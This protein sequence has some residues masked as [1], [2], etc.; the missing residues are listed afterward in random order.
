VACAA[1]SA[2]TASKIATTSVRTL[3]IPFLHELNCYAP[4]YKTICDVHEI[5]QPT[6]PRFRIHK[7][8]KLRR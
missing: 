8:K 6:F 4:Y 3:I 2:G 1:A 7:S 5:L